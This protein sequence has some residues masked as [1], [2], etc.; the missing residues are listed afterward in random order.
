MR[1]QEFIAEMH[2][3]PKNISKSTE[4]FF[5]CVGIIRGTGGIAY[6]ENPRLV[7]PS[8]VWLKKAQKNKNPK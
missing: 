2:L 8:N 4:F 7:T 5:S 1:K 6:E 3:K